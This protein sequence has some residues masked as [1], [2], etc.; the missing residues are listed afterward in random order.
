MKFSF[1]ILALTLT[2]AAAQDRKQCL[3]DVKSAALSLASAGVALEDSLHTC[4]NF[5]TECMDDIEAIAGSLDGAAHSMESAVVDCSNG[6]ETP[7]TKD[8]VN[9][10]DDINSAAES[11]TLAVTDC[12]GSGK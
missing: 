3:T 12:S 5:G 1:A 9:F 10:V 11:M 2:S 4:K 7:C 6:E 8:I